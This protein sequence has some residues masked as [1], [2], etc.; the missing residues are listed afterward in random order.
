MDTSTEEI[1]AAL[2]DSVKEVHRLKQQNQRLTGAANEPIAIVGMACALPGGVDS[3]EALW[4]LV[5][6]E[7]DAVGPFPGDRGW[8]IGALYHPDPDHPGTTYAREG[9]FLD[10]AGD[11]DAEL[12]GISPREA[13]AMDPQQRLLLETSWQALE[14]ARINPYSLHGTDT[15]VFAGLGAAG[16]AARLD[17]VPDDVGGYLGNGTSI[18][19]ASG[20][21]SYTLGL[22]GPAVTV[23]TACSSSLVAVHLAVRSLRHGECSLALAGGVSVMSNPGAFVDFSRQRGLAADGRCKAFSAS[24]DGTGWAEGAGVLVLE[25]LSEARRHGREVLAVI[26]GSAINQ[27]GASSGLTAPSGPAQQRVIRQALAAAGL[28]SADVDAVEGHGTGTRLGDPIEAQALLATYGKDRP[29]DRPLLLGSLKSNIGHTQTAAGAAGVIKMVLALRHGLLPRTLHVDTPTPEVDWSAGAVRLLTETRAWPVLGRPRRAGVSSFGASGTNAHIILEEAETAGSNAVRPVPVGP[30]DVPPEPAGPVLWPLSARSEQALLGQASRLR[31]HLAA[32]SSVRPVDVGWSLAHSRASLDHRAV[33][34]GDEP[35]QLLAALDE[36]AIRGVTGTGGR[37]AFLF[38]GQGAQRPGMGLGLV[39]RYPAFAE[40]FDRVCVELDRWVDQPVRQTIMGD[41]DRLGGTGSAQPALLALEIALFRLAES[42]GLRPDYLAGHSVGELAAAHVA[43]VLSLP[44]V[45]RL[46]AARGALMQALP[47]G[48]AMAAVQATEDEVGE[49]LATLPGGAEQVGVAAVN[50]PRSVVVSGDATGVAEVTAH[51]TAIGRRTRRLRV[52]HAFHSP[53]MD[54]MLAGYREVVEQVTFHPPRLP[55]VS[56]LTGRLAGDELCTPEYWVRHAREPVRFAEAVDVLLRSRVR[57]F[58]ELGPD[59]V[60]APMVAECL[61]GVDDVHV[62]P[63]LRAGRADEH[64]VLTALGELYVRGRDLDWSA[65]YA[66]RGARLVD[67]PTYAFQRDR[68]WLSNPA[69]AVNEIDSVGLNVVGHPLLGAALEL[70]DGDGVLFT[71]RLSARSQPWITE[72]VVLG[73]VLVPGSGLVELALR[74]GDE[75]GCPHLEELTLGNPLVLPEEGAIDLR[76]WIGPGDENGRRPL[77]V[78][79]R[80][81]GAAPDTTWT[82]NATGTLSAEQPLPP[83]LPAPPNWPPAGATPIAIDNL[84]DRFAELGFSYGPLFTGVRAAWRHGDEVYA[85][86]ALS[87]DTDADADRFNLHPALLDAAL[88]QA[89]ALG[90]WVDD[91]DEQ[92]RLPFSWTDVHLYRT[93]ATALRVR[94]ARTDAGGISL[95]AVDPDGEPVVSVGSLVLRPVSA[96]QLGSTAGRDESLLYQDWVRMTDHPT[97]AGPTV[98]LGTNP[99]DLPVTAAVVDLAALADQATGDPGGLTALLC[100]G[101]AAG[102]DVSAAARQTTM[103]VLRTLRDFLADERLAPVRLAIVTRGAVMVGD[104]P[105]DLALA[106]VWGLLRSAQAE[107]PERFVLVDLDPVDGLSKPAFLA[108]L[109]GHENEMVIRGE[110]LYVPRLARI[111]AGPTLVPPPT[112]HW[113]LD[114]TTRGTIENLALLAHPSAARSLEPG[115]V[116]IAVRAAGLNFRDVLIALGMYPGDAEMGGEGAGTVVE[117]GPGVTG[118]APGD[119]V[120]G[121]LSAGFGPLAV[122]DHR[123]LVRIPDGWSYERA[124]AVPI[125]F[126]TAAYG[127]LDLAGLASGASILVHAGT[128][129]VGM[130]AVRL[131]RHLGA[132]VYATASPAKWDVLRELGLDD[133]HISSSR[134]TEFTAKF[135]ATS[136]GRGVDVVLNSLAGEFV[137]ASLR[138]LAP[139]GRFIE[140]GK[141][142][143]R[144]PERVAQDH[145]GVTYRA[146]DLMEAGPDRLGELLTAMLDLFE[147]G[148]V[149]TLPVTGWDV[150]RAGAAF[151]H[152]SQARHVGKVVLTMPR[153]LDPARAVLVTGATGGLGRLVSRHLV[154]E[155]GVTDLL[156]VSRTGPRAEHADDLVAEL[157]ALGARVTLLACDV[158]DRTALAEL[159]DGRRLTA[160]VHLAGVVDDGVVSSLTAEQVARVFAAKVDAAWNLH[161]LTRDMDLSAFVLFSSA[162]GLFGGAGQGNYAA[163]NVFLDALAQWRRARQL[164]AIS[165]AWGLWAEPGGMAARLSGTDRSRVAQ[166]GVLALDS[167]EGLELL[168]TALRVDQAVVAPLRLDLTT[169]ARRAEVPALLSGLVR[170]RTGRGVR[171]KGGRGAEAPL[172]ARLAAV[173][174]DE[175]ERFLLDLVRDQAAAVLGHAS[176]DAV[177]ARRAFKDLGFDSLTAIELRNRINSVTGLRL[178]ATL[179]FD[180]PTPAALAEHVYA[181]LAGTATAPVAVMPGP[182]VNGDDPIAIVAMGCRFPGGVRTPED[183]WALLATGTDAVVDFPTDRGWNLDALYDP[184]PETPGTTYVRSGGFI[185]DVADFDPGPFGIGPREALAMDPQQRLLLEASWEVLE[186]AG[187]DPHSLRGSRTGVFVGTSG[188]DY[189]GLFGATGQ[190]ADG[191]LVTGNAASVLSGRV[192]YTFGLEGPA[193]TV[194]TA[195]SSSL[196]ALHLGAQALRQDE[197][198]LALVGGVTIMSSPTAFLDFSRQRGLAADGRCK[199]FSAAADGTGWGEGLGLLLLERLSDARRQGHPVLALVR[200]SAV[201]QDGASNGLTAPNG[202]S[203]QRVIRQAL[204]SAGLSPADV[205]AVEAHGTGTRLGDPIEAQALLATYGQDRPADRPL[206]LGSLKSNLGHTQAAAGAAGVIKMVLAMTNGVLPMTLHVDTPTPEVD[207]SAGGVRLL[208]G[209]HDWPETGRP[210]RAGVSSF[211]ISGTNA[212]VILEQADPSPPPSASA[213]PGPALWPLSGHSDSVVRAQAERLARGVAADPM[214]RPADIGRALATTR[215]ALPHRAVVIGEGRD[216]L[217]AGLASPSVRGVVRTG[218]RLAMV[219]TGQGAQRLGMGADLYRRFPRF[220]EAFD[221]VCAELDPLLDRPLREVVHGGETVDQSTALDETGYTQ[222]ALFAV[223]VA[224]FRLVESWGVRPDVVAGH[225]VGELVAAYAAGMLSLPDACRLVA[226]RG[227]LMQSLPSGG[228]MV[229]VQAAE[230]EVLQAVAD[231]PERMSIAAV[232]GPAAVVLSGEDR[233]VGEAA[234]KL[235]AQGHK[236]RRLRVSHAFH[237]PLMEP[238]LAQFRSVA[239]GVVFEPPRIPLVLSDPGADPATA[240]YWVRQVRQPVRFA[241]V[242]AELEARGVDT[243]VEV[244]PDAVLSAMVEDCLAGR[245]EQSAIPLLRRDRPEV[246]QVLTAVAE[247]FVRGRELDWEALYDGARSTGVQLP[248][249]PFER[250]RYWPT[251]VTDDARRDTVPPRSLRHRVVWKP[252]PTPATTRLA[253]TWLVAVP[254]EAAGAAQVKAVTSALTARGAHVVRVELGAVGGD[255]GEYAERL[256]ALEVEPLGVLSLLALAG[257]AGAQATVALVQALTDAGIDASVWCATTGASGPEQALV[258]GLGRVIRLEYPDRWGGLIE[259]PE[260]LDESTSRW[261]CDVLADPGGETDLA[262]RPGGVLARR[263]VRAP[264]DT[265]PTPIAWRPAGTVLITGGTGALGAHLARDLARA[266]TEHLVLTNRS[267]RGAAG[268]AALEAE[269]ISYGARVTVTA[270]DVTDRGAVLRLVEGITSEGRLAAVVHAAGVLDDCVIDSLTEQRLD[271]VLRPKVLGARHLDEATRE[272]ELE[273]FVLFSSLSATLGSAGQANYVAA[274]AYLDALAERRRADGLIATSVAWGPWAGGGMAMA[275]KVRGQSRQGGVSPMTPDLAL[276]ALRQAIGEDD[277]HVVIADVDWQR[278]LAVH[279]DPLLDELVQTAESHVE[280]QPTDDEPARLRDRLATAPQAQRHRIL[281]GLVRVHAAQ[282][283]GHPNVQTVDLGQ[284]F[285]EMG[286][287]SLGAVKLRNRLNR[288]TGLRLPS[289]TLFD[290]PTPSALAEHLVAELAPD[291]A[292]TVLAELDRL[293]AALAQVDMTAPAYPVISGRLAALASA[294]NRRSPGERHEE[295]DTASLD[296]VMNVIENELGL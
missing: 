192:A 96:A 215:P 141:S 245:D 255:R 186:R 279:P 198:S 118:L 116:R 91:G 56:T 204:S 221:A 265:A 185:R 207:W 188:Q 262:I 120:L 258:Q 127:L 295:L 243:F 287:D 163:A 100:V 253:G 176:T 3:P 128:G 19:V 76:V 201:N 6:Q 267:G 94:L 80:Q 134:D 155:H 82:A 271:R 17:A 145:P 223:E 137:D 282:V 37:L 278:L 84:Y 11:F 67:L 34:V 191:H 190:D 226:A 21:I 214:V 246:V 217:L 158:A 193:I 286:F 220:A 45:S 182:I 179:I 77:T 92:G 144:Q 78:H 55:I 197:C 71:S 173:P 257:E 276:A 249:Y 57:T 104:G 241:D 9:G 5:I 235:A 85:D 270:C 40:A 113:R 166:G 167:A 13:L 132:E 242:V 244:G 7:R 53:L 129:G 154:V 225:S 149:E 231:H 175:R 183:L 83:R 135:R 59:A 102:S 160:V 111:S 288:V 236:V 208:T 153:A 219:F 168:D 26:R 23:D 42:W 64:Q 32:D 218:G 254:A 252:V 205:D 39:D 105:L 50:G 46:V 269:L 24:A 33:V 95:A 112:P 228:A 90:T 123:T 275:D 172:A 178:P 79:S 283:L 25:R 2:R 74:A 272:L 109:A 180:H 110:H 177:S 20:R 14:R 119:A 15:G 222:P 162:A 169:M 68:Y 285:L 291:S 202:P 44:D 143:V 12:F 97:P 1:V 229:A 238:M 131:A 18:S 148:A 69:G 273:A 290:H 88:P 281:A 239:E 284:G 260:V 256:R 87:I 103:E 38:T 99:Y 122:A 51:F 274:N 43:G 156:L 264:V 187:I 240:D 164:P 199:A 114:V 181:G 195:C 125:A 268:V 70:V 174:S 142:D 48:G 117:V 41:P 296:E 206:L 130:A 150:R 133:A 157:T 60:L 66:T 52:S 49:L 124:A 261:L 36:L 35:A 8:D 28:S 108:A 189:A 75:A 73:A 237:S 209:R 280:P 65:L 62:V 146:F 121:L 263:L 292:T 289:S 216:E 151:R 126:L 234:E 293:E 165:L 140:M 210:R 86:V 227:R 29:A 200:G 294:W 54:P 30:D 115:E 63:T 170:T 81:A 152:V 22:E 107:H 101:A 98:V 31:D 266:G 224:L 58:V 248:T 93:G 196:V 194:D 147:R 233:I 277:T 250:R 4:D 106:P 159:L 203:Q 184:D 16:Y 171:A 212:H 251:A 139:G 136:A 232:N 10:R 61:G 211:G 138:V 230:H 72:H 259:L 27:D 247:L 89:L 213:W 47:E 161:E